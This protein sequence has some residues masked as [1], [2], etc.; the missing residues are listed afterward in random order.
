M[1]CDIWF[2]MVAMVLEELKMRINK[3]KPRGWQGKYILL[4]QQSKRSKS[5]PYAMYCN[6]IRVSPLGN[7]YIEIY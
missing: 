5:T 6:L 4:C 3:H 1:W 7:A 2:A